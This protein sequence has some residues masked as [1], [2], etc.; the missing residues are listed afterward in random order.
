[1]R[2]EKASALLDLARRLAASAEGLGTCCIGFAVPM[3]NTPETKAEL[4]VPAALRA[5]A[6]I[7]IGVPTEE[8]PPTPRKTPVVI[9]WIR[10]T[11]AGVR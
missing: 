8:T 1:M 10:D 11:P 9:S 6:P 4:G 3:L 7:I 2:H 5:V